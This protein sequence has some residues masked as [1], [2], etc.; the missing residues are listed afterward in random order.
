V[1]LRERE[2]AMPADTAALGRTL[3]RA[4]DPY[5]VIG[6]SLADVVRDADFAGLYEG[7][8]RAA[9]PPSVL[10]LVTVFQFL[11]GLP[12]R[13]AARAVAT[14]LDWKYALRLPLA[15]PGFEFTVLHYFRERVLAGGKDG[16]LF[17]AV[18][19]KVTALGLLK[20]RKQRTDATGVLAAV[21]DLSRLETATETL[22]LAVRAIE[23]AAP[24]WAGR[25]LPPG[26]RERH[27]R[28]VPEYRL[29]EAERAAA[30]REAAEDGYWLLERLADA[31]AAVRALEAV[32]VLG[33]VWAQR[34]E[35]G[36]D[37]AARPRADGGPDCTERLISP[38]DPGARAGRKRGTGWVGEKVHV[39]ETADAVGPNFLTDIATA[40]A[41]ARDLEALPGIRRR[42][43]ERGLSPDEQDVDAGYISGRQLAES[44]AAGI[45]LVGPPPEDTS[46]NGFKLADFAL[47]RERQVATCPA[48]VAS[49]KWAARTERDGS[50]AIQIRFPAAACAACPLRAR[51][52][53]SKTGRSLSLSEHHARLEARRAE[54]KTPEFRERLKARA[55]IEGTISELVRAHGL[56][57]HR[58]R[59][60][61][62]RH[63][64]NLLK[65][66]ACNLKRLA[67]ALAARPALAAAAGAPA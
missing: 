34:F 61:A 16:L 53:A 25:A 57:R 36:A 8:G 38:H 14:R 4:G 11:E 47:D 29:S 65:G 49:V 44:E 60:D 41:A 55:A 45:E 13:Q 37:A 19:G 63:F 28:T 15:S 56:R 5:R 30:L 12:D 32:G 2:L 26:Y 35:R 17:E 51:C 24:A 1:T 33:T 27:A 43:A 58:Y 59:G 46:P 64:E 21:R 42:L 3:L 7:I 67:R 6:D 18:L 31:P 40:N 48:G 9:I 50:A 54:A 52:T 10:A 66:A 22:R 20:R 23:A 62:K 39:T